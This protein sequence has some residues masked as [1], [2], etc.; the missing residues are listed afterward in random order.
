MK[1]KKPKNKLLK[2]RVSVRIPPE[3]VFESKKNPI[4]RARI[5]RKGKKAIAEGLEELGKQK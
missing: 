2:S 5:R 4:S 3:Q 1:K